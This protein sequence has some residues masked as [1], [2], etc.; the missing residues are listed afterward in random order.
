MFS[1]DFCEISQNTFFTKHLRVTASD[2]LGIYKR[3]LQNRRSGFQSGGEGGRGG[4]E[5]GGGGGMEHWKVLSATMVGR[6]EKFSN[7]RRSR[8]DKTIIFWPWWQP[9][10]SFCCETLSFL[11]LSPFFLL[12]KK[13]GGPWSPRR[14]WCRRPWIKHTICIELKQRCQLL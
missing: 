14:A 8:M 9:F 6:Q 3:R 10:N 2:R 1:C 5:R 7:S 12:R 4:R 11:P 13:V